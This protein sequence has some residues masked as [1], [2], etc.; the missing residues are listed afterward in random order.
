MRAI[1]V[2]VCVLGGCGSNHTRDLAGNPYTLYFQCRAD[3]PRR[4]QYDRLGYETACP[5]LIEIKCGDDRYQIALLD[6]R[7][8][9]AR[10]PVGPEEMCRRIR[11]AGD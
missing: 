6:Y 3:S 4:V 2:L 10:P 1:A 8:Y 11:A 5:N 9:Y 7:G